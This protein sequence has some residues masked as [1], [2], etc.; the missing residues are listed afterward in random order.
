MRRRSRQIL[1]LSASIIPSTNEFSLGDLTTTRDFTYVE[2]TCRG[3]LAIAEMEGRSGE[4]F[5]IGSNHEISIAD[6]VGLISDIMGTKFRVI[7][8]P[9]R[10]R[11]E[12]SEVLR[13]KCENS[14]LKTACGLVPSLS[15]RQGL[16]STIRWFTEPANLR[17]CKGNLH[18]V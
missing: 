12:K 13:L 6:L 9:Q 4:V 8:D 5:N 18:N 1:L 2:D 16:E 3:F 17:R 7:C 11:P 14:K 10:I 15:M